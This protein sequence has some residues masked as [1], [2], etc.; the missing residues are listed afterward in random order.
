MLVLC[1]GLI[2]QGLIQGHQEVVVVVVVVVVAVAGV[3][4]IRL[5]R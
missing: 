1:S 5:G 4:L 3:E 2:I